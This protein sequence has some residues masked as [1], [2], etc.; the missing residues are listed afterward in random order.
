MAALD[1]RRPGVW[2]GEKPTQPRDD[3]L[4]VYKNSQEEEKKLL[5]IC[6]LLKMGDFSL[7]RELQALLLTS[8]NAP[9][10]EFALRLYFGV[11][12]HRGVDFFW[13]LLKSPDYEAAR[14]FALYAPHSLSPQVLPYLF[15]LL[16]EF[17]DSVLRADIA[18]SIHALY[19]MQEEFNPNLDLE[20]LRIQY[21]RASQH[22]EDGV[23]YF[24]GRPAF[25]GDLTKPLLSAAYQARARGDALK[26]TDE[27]TLVSIWSGV[28]CPAD[29]STLVDDAGLK[30]LM[31]YVSELAS[32]PWRK[33]QKYFYN[34]PIPG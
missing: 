29:Y 1:I 13:D 17:Y 24:R 22:I 5:A 18:Y 25:I 26:L 12:D 34:H 6:E 16:E 23:Y 3:A 15:A 20:T 32:K 8:S 9:V 11:T 33:G 4:W 28:K 21:R 14:I 2:F 31:D 10:K 19:P 27:P 30:Q 7:V